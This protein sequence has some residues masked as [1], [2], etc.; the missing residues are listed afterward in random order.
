MLATDLRRA[1]W[2]PAGDLE[3]SGWT[4]LPG[5]EG[6]R[7]KLRIFAAA[8]GTALLWRAKTR[9]RKDP[10]AN[11]FSQILPNIS[12]HA[13]T[14]TLSADGLADLLDA[15]PARTAVG[16]TASWRLPLWVELDY[17]DV[18]YRSPVENHAAAGSAAALAGR[19]VGERLW[20]AGGW[21]P[22][23]GFV[24]SVRTDCVVATRIGVRGDEVAID[25][26][27]LG[28]A[29][30]V[31]ATLG[32]LPRPAE[33]DV[34]SADETE[35]APVE[36]WSTRTVTGSV[37]A[38]SNKNPTPLSWVAADGARHPVFADGP[39]LAYAGESD[40]ALTLAEDATRVV[41][42]L[43]AERVVVVDDLVL[44]GGRPDS[45]A[46]VEP[47]VVIS[48]TISGDW[49][50]D[51]VLELSG[52]RDRFTGPVA[53]GPFSVE[54]P[55]LRADRWGNTGLTPTP[56]PYQVW[57]R[58]GADHR[59]RGQLSVG[60]AAQLDRWMPAERFAL[61]LERDVLAPAVGELPVPDAL[62]LKVA[63]PR[64]LGEIGQHAQNYLRWRFHRAVDPVE[65]ED[66]IYFES[67]IGKFCACNPK[68]VFDEVGRRD[69]GLT[70]YFGVKDHSVPVP[71]GAVPLIIN[72][73]EWWRVRHQARYLVTND[74]LH[75]TY[76][77]RP[78]QRVLQ[79]WHGTALKL[80][81]LDRL[82][83]R[84][85]SWFVK[86]VQ[87][88]SASWDLLLAENGYSVDLMRGAYDYAGTVLESGYPR[89]DILTSTDAVGVRDRLRSLLGITP[90]QKAV[91]YA[92]TWRE[93][94]TSMVDDLDLA[95]LARSLGEDYVVLARGHGNTMRGNA[96]IAADRVIDVTSYPEASDLYCAADVA[97]TDYSS[98][99]FD[100]TVT[101]KPLL[102]FTP[103]Y[104][105]YLNELR[106]VYFDLGEV[107]PGPMLTR[108]V[109]LADA[110][111]AA[112]EI[113]R[114]WSA[115]YD[116]WTTRFNAWDDGR[117]SARAVDA[118][119]AE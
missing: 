74:W 8:T 78:H 77:H 43:R 46:G 103:D 104:D 99:M 93:D 9:W 48:G 45:A 22:G 50:D 118:L 7:A 64:P 107:S 109:E 105:S 10:E 73:L 26:L 60:L 16:G 58:D 110:V 23:D 119:L 88:E 18:I 83:A 106:G 102:F 20:V 84:D 115:R 32:R 11:V 37:S 68:A 65:V 47:T 85:K 79:T 19:P 113:R 94:R 62:V 116:A 92:P 39:Q 75:D 80:L 6:E 69:L 44:T 87:A 98:V 67:F 40:G 97:I 34:G 35:A 27:A 17:G 53:P 63:D 24:L 13:W 5:R 21:V 1:Q 3:L 112:D 91:L 52:P 57:V 72:S 114:D 82:Q 54:L 28:E 14:A 66:A 36:Q 61:R 15:D 89:N 2:T 49:A 96:E 90:D 41:N 30:A 38:L 108:Q 4:Y 76:Q 25:L 86:M 81:A 55:L 33:P 95:G 117:S 71:E 51:L 111:R 29:R 31:D 70:R 101:G 59:Q 42:L 12:T 100:F 56:G